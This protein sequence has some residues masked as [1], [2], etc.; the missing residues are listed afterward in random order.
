MR[1][2]EVLKFFSLWA[3][4][5]VWA[6]EEEIKDLSHGKLHFRSSDVYLFVGFGTDIEWIDFA[7]AEDVSIR[8]NKPVFVLIHKTWCG[9]CK[10][11]KTSF[12]TSPK[13]KEFIQL[14]RK[15]VMVNLEVS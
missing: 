8:L 4:V 15:F 2:Q 6:K 7:E 5:S 12:N 9:A 11:L 10:Q 1:F 3:I 13:R 14:T